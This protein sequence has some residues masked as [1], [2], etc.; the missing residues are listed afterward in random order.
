VTSP[1]AVVTGIS[2]N[3]SL[4]DAVTTC[5]AVRAR[6]ARPLPLEAE[7]WTEEDGA[8]PVTGHPVATV[9]GF[10]GE[11]RLLALAVE[12]LSRLW[13]ESKLG[14]SPEVALLLALP[15]LQKRAQ[16]AQTTLPQ[17]RSLVDRLASLAGLPAAGAWRRTFALGHAGFAT[18]VDAA[19][20]LLAHGDVQTC[21]VGGVDTLCDEV[22]IE[23][24]TAQ[25][26]LKTDDN[27]VGLQPGEAAAFLLLERPET[28]RQR[29]ARTLA[30][31]SGVGI[32]SQPQAEKEPP[33]GQG[34][35]AALQLLLAATG[36]LAPG[37]VFFVL[38]RNGETA[39]A[40]DWGYCLQRITGRIPGLLP[41][42]QWD[43]AT[44]LGDTGAASGALGAQLAIRAFARG[45]APGVS[46]IVLSASES[47]ARTALRLEQA[48]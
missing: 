33:L 1:G 8:V 3:T 22:A 44:S 34:L 45:Y 17:S 18:A 40:N 37:G 35:L 9:A 27:P 4:G 13:Q 48:R 12:P 30:R 24:L 21:I 6:L 36:P 14:A 38:D 11:A 41:A 15:D 23:A 28:A 29:G 43:P 47:G 32:A 31:V 46:G 20:K 2:A 7:A 39:R 10:Q 19:L 16:A 42:A 5:A 26:Q 25:G